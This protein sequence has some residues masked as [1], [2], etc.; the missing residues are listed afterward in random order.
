MAVGR[1]LLPGTALARR[2]QVFFN[3]QSSSWRL[4]SI[5][6]VSSRLYAPSGF[7]P[8]GVEIGSGEFVGG[9]FGAFLDRV[10]S[11]RSK[12][13]SAK[14]LFPFVISFFFTTLCV[15]VTPPLIMKL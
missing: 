10:F 12:G 5:V 15:F 7:V 8:G 14:S 3:L 13:F 2:L 4:K 6:G 11:R 1:P 9:G